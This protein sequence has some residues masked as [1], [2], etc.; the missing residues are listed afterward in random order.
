MLLVLGLVSLELGLEGEM[1]YAM[2]T[3]SLSFHGVKAEPGQA[4]AVSIG[5]GVTA[6]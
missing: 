5:V 3:Q 6:C 1:M 4:H 2:H